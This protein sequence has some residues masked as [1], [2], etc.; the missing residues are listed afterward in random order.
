MPED[1]APYASVELGAEHYYLEI[2]TVRGSL[3]LS[4]FFSTSLC[5]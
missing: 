3:S 5:S 4:R 1:E 2:T